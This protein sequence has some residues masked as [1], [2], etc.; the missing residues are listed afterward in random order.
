MKVFIDGFNE[1][2]STV[3]AKKRYR[4]NQGAKRILVYEQVKNVLCHFLEQKNLGVADTDT[5]AKASY[6]IAVGRV[7]QSLLFLHKNLGSLLVNN[8]SIIISNFVLKYLL[9]LVP[10]K[11]HDVELNRNQQL[12]KN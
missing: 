3:L 4:Q 7:V 11:V 1:G 12:W 10:K 5:T 2:C 8:S 9:S 6:E